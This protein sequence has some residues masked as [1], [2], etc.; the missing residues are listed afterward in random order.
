MKLLIILIGLLGALS[1]LA[2]FICF[3]LNNEKLGWAFF[4]IFF[5]LALL[6]GL[7]EKYMWWSA[8]GW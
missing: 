5:V 2:A 6:A 7:L 3:Y 4:V 1:C 8:L